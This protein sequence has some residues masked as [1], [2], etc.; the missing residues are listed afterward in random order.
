MFRGCSQHGVRGVTPYSA[1]DQTQVSSVQSV[2]TNL[3]GCLLCS[4]SP[5][6]KQ[7]PERF[8]D[9]NLNPYKMSE[10]AILGQMQEYL[11]VPSLGRVGNASTRPSPHP[12]Q[13]NMAS[14]QPR[15]FPGAKQVCNPLHRGWE[16]MARP[17][18][19]VLLVQLQWL[20]SSNSAFACLGRQKDQTS[21]VSG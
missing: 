12:S 15:S 6:E 18:G 10:N 13:T 17:Q 8:S 20:V 19:R 7:K 1:E 9:L 16:L 21:W 3:S 5:M 14:A 11:S 2:Y 4:R